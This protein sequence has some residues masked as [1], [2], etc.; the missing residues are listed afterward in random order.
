MI[1]VIVFGVGMYNFGWN[2]SFINGISKV[3]PYPAAI[4]D[5]KIIKYVNYLEDVETL[6]YYYNSFEDESIVPP[7]DFIEKSV[8]A[9]MIREK[10]ISMMAKKYNLSV[11][12]KEVD[13]E[14]GVLIGQADDTSTVADSLKKL[15][16]W[17]EDEFKNKVIKPYLLRNKV[18]EYI[19]S[20]ES[21][22]G[23]AQT[24]AQEVLEKVKA[25]DQTFE[26]LAAEY[27]DDTSTGPNG[28]DL[29]YFGK[30][31]MVAEFETAAF[32][33]EVGE[34]SG[35]VQTQY[36]YHI[37]KLIERIPASDSGEEQLHAAH[38]LI[39]TKDI[40]EWSNE[41][42]AKKKVSVYVNDYEWKND[43]GLVLTAE[44]TCLDNNMLQYL[45]QQQPITDTTTDTTI[46]T[47]TDT[48][49][50]DQAE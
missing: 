46:D 10:F 20:D 21:I 47:S 37:I 34:V 16:N 39:T 5:G 6:A 27:S 19:Q 14:Y 9:R 26:D 11:T 36:G 15:Y 50:A 3:V 48:N 17:T 43:C 23:S 13:D 1:L 40:D 28:G 38:I 7:N 4:Y 49:T 31:Q 18:H 33:L 45:N 35:I 29:G 2:N 24:R 8:L 22:G 12:Q 44:E 25:G 30:N 41:E 42:I 32:A